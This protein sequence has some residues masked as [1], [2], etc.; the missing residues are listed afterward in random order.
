MR[1][2]HKKRAAPAKVSSSFHEKKSPN[3]NYGKKIPQDE[4]AAYDDIQ[5]RERVGGKRWI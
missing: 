3:S 4:A 5:L 2:K 1:H